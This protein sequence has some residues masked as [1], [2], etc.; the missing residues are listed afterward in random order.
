MANIFTPVIP[1]TGPWTINREDCIGDSL[2]YI[3]ANTNYFGTQ[4]VALS[5]NVSSISS[6]LTN[7]NTVV[8]TL[9]SSF[10][11]S[12]SSNGWQKFP[13][14]LIM[15][16]GYALINANP[17]TYSFPIAFPNKGFQ[18]YISQDADASQPVAGGQIISST[19]FKLRSMGGSTQDGI[20]WFAIGC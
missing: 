11:S 9:S 2:G 17:V 13:S 16:W 10:K 12:L 15:Q 6:T 20:F 5:T 19:Q 7:L 1:A 14:G 18:I 8:T 4:I 3:N